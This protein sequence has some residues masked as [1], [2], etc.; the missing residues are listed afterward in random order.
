MLK[1]GAC[2]TESDREFHMRGAAREKA[3]LPYC[4]SVGFYYKEVLPA[5]KQVPSR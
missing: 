5:R 2:L 4:E 3:R 1:V